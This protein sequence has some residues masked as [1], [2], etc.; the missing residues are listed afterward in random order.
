MSSDGEKEDLKE[1]EG[2]DSSSP[3]P[4]APA[5]SDVKEDQEVRR[6]NGRVISDF[7]GACGSLD[8]K[9]MREILDKDDLDPNDIVDDV[10]QN[11]FHYAVCSILRNNTSRQTSV[12]KYLR[13]KGLN[14]NKAR[15]TD[16]WTP[17][18][19]AVAFGFQNIVSWLL[20]KGARIDI[21]D[22]ETRSPEEVA[23]TYRF[24]KIKDI[25]IHHRSRVPHSRFSC[26]LSG[27]AI[28]SPTSPPPP[29]PPTTTTTIT[30]ISSQEPSSTDNNSSVFSPTVEGEAAENITTIKFHV[31]PW[32]LIEAGYAGLWGFF[33]LTASIAVASY[34]NV[35]SA[36][37]AA[38]FFGFVAMVLYI[39]DAV[40]KLKGFRGGFISQHSTAA[41]TPS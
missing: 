26:V 11:G 8:I 21:S 9:K 19:L 18:F 15:T 27:P 6:P 41:N 24:H 30:N 32:N 2:G 22:S 23:A 16:K 5:S 37:G 12:L 17:I 13:K 14:V 29:A 7:L 38:A 34:A 33:Y 1:D 31:I 10:G 36:F 4:V 40:F 28:S 3:P 39:V 25:L 20:S 35:I